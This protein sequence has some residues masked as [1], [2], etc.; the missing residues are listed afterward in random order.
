MHRL[1]SPVRAG[2]TYAGVHQ[3]I[4]LC[5]VA[6]VFVSEYLFT[7]VGIGLCLVDLPALCI[8]AISRDA[9]WLHWEPPAVRLAPAAPV[10]ALRYY[11]STIAFIL[12]LGA[13]QWFLIGFAT[14]HLGQA[15]RLRAERNFH[16]AG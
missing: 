2:L 3:L 14:S 9:G 5:G 13:L 10:A 16:N 11:Q 12:I 8:N 15:K 1:W 6:S 4:A 7:L